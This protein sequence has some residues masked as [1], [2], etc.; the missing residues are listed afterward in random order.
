MKNLLLSLLGTCLI[1]NVLA[2]RP[3]RPA[4]D[5]KRLLMA[6]KVINVPANEDTLLF[7]QLPRGFR[8]EGNS[9]LSFLLHDNGTL[10]LAEQ[11]ALD[12]DD[13]HP[14]PSV[15]FLSGEPDRL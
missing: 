13:E 15:Q 8:A 2:Q 3:N 4:Q 1:S 14:R 7:Y 9:K 6:G 11:I 12:P 10:L 5:H